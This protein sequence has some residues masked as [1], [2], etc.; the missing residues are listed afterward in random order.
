MAT[1]DLTGA[2]AQ[3]VAWEAEDEDLKA[4]FRAGIPIHQKNAEEMFGAEVE[5]HAAARGGP[6]ENPGGDHTGD[7]ANGHHA[8][9]DPPSRGHI[10]TVFWPG[11]GHIP[12][13]KKYQQTK[14]GVHAIDYGAAPPTVARVLDSTL[15]KG[16]EFKN[17]WFSLHPNI[18]NVWHE[19]VEHELQTNRTASNRFGYRIRYFDRI[20]K[21][22]PEALAWGPQSTVAITCNRGGKQLRKAISWVT[23]LMQVH[24]ELVFQF[25]WRYEDRLTQIRDALEVVVPY[26]DPLIIPWKLSMSKKSWADCA[27]NARDW[28]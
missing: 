16:T 22:L 28:E 20:A 13:H 26:A 24:D 18:P 8:A 2:D 10:A 6:L 25:P 27:E 3:V 15:A 11:R 19:K 17:R 9:P 14:F 5:S 7:H 21:L 1:V 4:A 23:L 12:K